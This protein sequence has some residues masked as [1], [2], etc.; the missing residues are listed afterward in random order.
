MQKSQSVDYTQ[1]RKRISR[2]FIGILT[3]RISV[4]DALTSFPKDCEDKTLIAAWHALCHYEADE[5]LRAKDEMY[6]EE[7]DEYIGYIANILSKGE[8][9]PLN[10]INE[11][12]PYH[13]NALIPNSTKLHG[14][15]Q[16]IK[17]FLCC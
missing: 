9:L 17:K 16:N 7:Q 10:I 1:V 12:L 15:L 2:L 13:E 8:E 6:K 14:I 5:E 3:K 4:R 11:Y